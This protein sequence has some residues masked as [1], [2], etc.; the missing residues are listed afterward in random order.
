[1]RTQLTMQWPAFLEGGSTDDRAIFHGDMLE[2][3]HTAIDPMMGN[4]RGQTP[5]SIASHYDV[6]DQVTE[7]GV[8]V[9]ITN[10]SPIRA[11]WEED[12][13]PHTI[14]P[15]RASVLAFSV[16]GS[17]VFSRIMH[18]PGTKGHH[19]FERV[20]Q[21]AQPSIQQAIQAGLNAYMLDTL[22]KGGAL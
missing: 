21:G 9:S 2:S 13:R 6:Q 11:F 19:V 7:R 4:V 3:L 10:D 17:T 5:Q 18:H 20:Y 22:G 8:S 16:G 15:V 12:T 14:L 1:M